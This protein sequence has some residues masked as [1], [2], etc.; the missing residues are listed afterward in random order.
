MYQ[1]LVQLD[2]PPRLDQRARVRVVPLDGV[3]RLAGLHRLDVLRDQRHEPGDVLGRDE[4]V[5]RF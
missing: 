3:P 5:A 2:D 1:P 4:G